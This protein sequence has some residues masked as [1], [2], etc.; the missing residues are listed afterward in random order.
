MTT[1]LL[2]ASALAAA[3]L[4]ASCQPPAQLRVENAY[5]Q[6]SPLEERPSAGY[7]TV[8]GG[9]E[10]V[11]L[12]AVTAS[13]ALRTEMHETLMENGAMSMRPVT[14]V[15]VGKRERVA[16]EPGGKHLMLWG[17]DETARESGNLS[18]QFIFSNGERIV[19]NAPLRTVGDAAAAE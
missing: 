4:L 6:L 5:I 8:V 11:S 18:L 16:F 12:R 17:I 15:D 7:F 19:V 3:T 1:R 14:S 2:K 10:P 13:A 9:A